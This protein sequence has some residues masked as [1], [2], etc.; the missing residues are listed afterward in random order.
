MREVIRR[1]TSM[2]D[3][4]N[5]ALKRG[6]LGLQA[7]ALQKVLDGITSIQEVARAV[8]GPETPPKAGPAATPAPRP[9]PQPKPQSGAQPGTAAGGS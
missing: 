2:A 4:Q 5:Y 1:S 7:Q 8:R 9:R 3:I 6:G